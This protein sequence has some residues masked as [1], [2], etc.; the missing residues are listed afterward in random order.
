MKKYSEVRNMFSK[1]HSAW[2]DRKNRDLNCFP[3]WI[4]PLF[5]EENLKNYPKQ[6]HHFEIYSLNMCLSHVRTI[7][8]KLRETLKQDKLSTKTHFL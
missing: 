1:K 4:K 3:L 7:Y 6:N 8:S 2:E 5:S